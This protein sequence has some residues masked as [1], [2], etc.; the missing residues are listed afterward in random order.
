[1]GFG[2]KKPAMAMNASRL[3]AVAGASAAPAVSA[4][5]APMRRVSVEPDL[6][7]IRKCSIDE[8]PEER[9]KRLAAK[10]VNFTATI[11]ARLIIIGA[12]GLFA[13]SEFQNTGK[14]HRGVALG[15]FAMTVDLGR[16]ILKA[17]EPGSK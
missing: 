14:F 9:K 4:S 6:S 5:E 13:W 3:A 15:I 17:L 11:I 1:M 16:V 2:G 7:R 10:T 8:T 12:A